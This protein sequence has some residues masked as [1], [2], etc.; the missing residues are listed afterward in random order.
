MNITLKI[1]LSDLIIFAISLHLFRVSEDDKEMQ[2]IFVKIL[3][4]SF[5]VELISIMTLIWQS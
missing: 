1:L 4:I 2:I 5:L 3:A